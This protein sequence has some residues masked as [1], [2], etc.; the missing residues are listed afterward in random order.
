MSR[1]GCERAKRQRLISDSF[2]TR[3]YSRIS[4]RNLTLEPELN[5]IT[6]I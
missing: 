2:S 1:S 6:T 4:R 3:R 5:A